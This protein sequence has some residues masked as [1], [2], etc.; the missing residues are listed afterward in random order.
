M[1]AA[2]LWFQLAPM[3]IVRLF[4]ESDS[5]YLEFAVKCLRIY[6]LLIVV[7]VFQMTGSIF[8]QSLGQPV[9]AA[10]LTLIR[11]IIIVIPAMFLLGRWFG[12]E[13]LLWSGPVSM[14]LTAIVAVAFLRKAWKEL[15]RNGKENIIG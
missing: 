1:L 13:G 3:S 7:D 5:L 11:Q 10:V 9:R 8:L 6:L 2:T 14:G 12:V 4:G 15:P